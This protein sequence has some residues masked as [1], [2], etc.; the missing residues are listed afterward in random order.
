MSSAPRFRGSR[1]E[2]LAEGQRFVHLVRDGERPCP[3]GVQRGDHRGVDLAGIGE[4]TR[5]AVARGIDETLHVAE[6]L[7]RGRRLDRGPLA[8]QRLR[9]GRRPGGHRSAEEFVATH[10]GYRSASRSSRVD[11]KSTRL[12]SSH[13]R[14]SYAVFCLKKKMPESS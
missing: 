10:A 4:R 13:V 11:R 6:R 8:G 3:D 14:I 7:D 12:N 9:E 1:S 2:S 5:K